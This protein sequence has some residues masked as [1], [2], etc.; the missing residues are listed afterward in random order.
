MRR[1]LAS[2]TCFSTKKEQAYKLWQAILPGFF[3]TCA[4]EEKPNRIW[5]CGALAIGIAFP[6]IAAILFVLGR[7]QAFSGKVPLLRFGN[8]DALHHLDSTTAKPD[9]SL[10]QRQWLDVEYPLRM[11]ARVCGWEP[12][13][14]RNAPCLFH[15]HG[16]CARTAE[17]TVHPR[18][19][20]R[21]QLRSCFLL[22]KLTPFYLQETRKRQEKKRQWGELLC[23]S[24]RPQ[25]AVPRIR[26]FCRS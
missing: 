12:E 1:P 15:S 6:I 9:S 5:S 2:P 20:L 17:T 3:I 11:L 4:N 7:S 24:V 8:K 25:P 19:R 26:L 23:R 21:S 22:P 13:L 18:L 14:S 16:V 10:L